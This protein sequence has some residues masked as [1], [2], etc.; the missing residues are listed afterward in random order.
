VT[1]NGTIKWRFRL[2]GFRVYTLN[3]RIGI[4]LRNVPFTSRDERERESEKRDNPS[5]Y[6]RH[7]VDK[8]GL[9]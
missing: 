9:S 8:R 5:I 3:I 4:V 2:F 6:L 7:T 1:K